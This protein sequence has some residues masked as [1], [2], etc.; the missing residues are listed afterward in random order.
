MRNTK[1]MNKIKKLFI[2]I[3]LT[4]FAFSTNAQG[5]SKNVD[6]L[7]TVVAPI[8]ISVGNAMQFGDISRTSAA[9]NGTAAGGV[10][11]MDTDGDVTTFSGGVQA[12][13]G[14][15]ATTAASITVTGEETATFS[16]V[17]TEATPLTLLATATPTALQKMELTNFTQSGAATGN[18]LSDNGSLTITIGADITVNVLQETGSYLGSILVVAEYE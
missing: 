4:G 11:R 15:T 5:F 8:E 12:V 1:F 17:I 13:A 2:F 3:L 7:A 9:S 14:G 6:A 16:L 18:L 10:L